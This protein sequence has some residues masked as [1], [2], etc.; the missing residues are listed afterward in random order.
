MAKLVPPHGSETLMP[1][2]LPEGER[3]AELER[4]KAMPQVKMT[5]RE[6]SDLIMMGIGAFTPLTGFMGEADWKGACD[7]MVLSNGV[8]LPIP[9]T[10]LGITGARSRIASRS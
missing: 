2:L 9:I 4:A 8:F 7:P 6:T 3:A 1:L 10:L 5:T